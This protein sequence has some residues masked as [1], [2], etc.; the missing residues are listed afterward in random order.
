[1]DQLGCDHAL[2]RKEGSINVV[3]R[4]RQKFCINFIILENSK[5]ATLA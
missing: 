4:A 5:A 1:M 2:I 3:L